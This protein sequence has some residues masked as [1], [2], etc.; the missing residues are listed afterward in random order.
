MMWVNL[1]NYMYGNL[2]PQHVAVEKWSFSEVRPD[3][4]ENSGYWDSVLRRVNECPGTQI[5]SHKNELRHQQ[6]QSPNSSC[7]SRLAV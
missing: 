5:S 7:F 2:G 3:R 4:K 1:Q 6:A